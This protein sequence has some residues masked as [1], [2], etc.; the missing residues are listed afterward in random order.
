MKRIVSILLVLILALSALN[1]SA[2]AADSDIWVCKSP[3]KIME[4]V[5][6]NGS[7]SNG[8]RI[9]PA[10]LTK[11]GKTTDIYLI[12][13]VGLSFS[14]SNVNSYLASVFS[15]MDLGNEYLSLVE[16]TIIN[17]VPQG[18]K[19]VI[20]GHSLG[21]MV[22]QQLVCNN[23]IK[24]KYEIIHVLTAGSPYI[25]S[26]SPEGSLIRLVDKNDIVPY[27]SIAS[28]FA[29]GKQKDAVKEDGGYT[30]MPRSAH[31]LSYLKEDVWGK[32]DALGY[33][34]GNA[35]IS[36]DNSDTMFFSTK[37]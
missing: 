28:V 22:A 15:S 1:F 7:K 2:F 18:S 3:A 12:G 32:Y 36:F 6:D 31:N 26:N 21:G 5:L 16:K 24:E 30:G 13:L 34:K 37:K 17:N 20:A 14:T 4:F 29:S 23:E 19:L 8:I 9:V 25:P 33:K 35:T 10:K 11:D 27:L